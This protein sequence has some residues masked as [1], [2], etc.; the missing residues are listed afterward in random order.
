M[1]R[2]WITL[3]L[4]CV[5]ALVAAQTPHVTFPASAVHAAVIQYDLAQYRADATNQMPVLRTNLG[6]PTPDANGMM[7]V[8]FTV[9]ADDPAAWYRART[10][11]IT[12][13]PYTAWT[14]EPSLPYPAV[15]TPIGCPVEPPSAVTVNP[16]KVRAELP[17][18]NAVLL[19]GT[20][21]VTGYTFGWYAEGASAPTSSA[22]LAKTAFVLV[23][24]TTFCY[25]APLPFAGI[26]I[27]QKYL[28]MLKSLRGTMESVW[29]GPSNP[30]GF[31][32]PVV[33]PTWL[34]IRK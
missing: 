28:A 34:R 7:T 27:G 20:P 8:P 16:T 9:P 31:E 33:P 22:P 17:E 25:E 6:T 4:L 24:G 19:D 15:Q 2:F 14:S 10:I 18:Q 32:G 13:S 12:E 30:F 5:P 26:P 29:S 23:G 3:L 1:R 21:S 11:A